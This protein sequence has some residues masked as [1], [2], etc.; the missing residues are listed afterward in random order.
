MFSAAHSPTL[1]AEAIAAPS[2]AHQKG[3]VLR[4]HRTSERAAVVPKVVIFCLV[5][6][7]LS[8]VV[9][10]TAQDLE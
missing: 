6:G 1:R 8:A 7:W 4:F 3:K 10:H 2:E 5:S 9:C